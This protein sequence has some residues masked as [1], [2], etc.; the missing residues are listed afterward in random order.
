MFSCLCYSLLWLLLFSLLLLLLLLSL[1]FLLLVLLL[2][3]S[4]RHV[5]PIDNLRSSCTRSDVSACECLFVCVRV[6]ASLCVTLSW[7]VKFSSSTNGRAHS[8]AFGRTSSLC[9]HLVSLWS[10]NGIVIPSHLL[11][12]FYL[13]RTFLRPKNRLYRPKSRTESRR[14]ACVWFNFK[15]NI[16][17]V[18]EACLS[19]FDKW[20]LLMF[21]WCCYR[22]KSV[23]L[24]HTH[25]NT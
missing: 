16:H 3:S 22:A 2:P 15:N 13:L 6:T 1:S 9:I 24:V 23:V 14:A 21:K 5:T 19:V 20:K 7:N 18:T 25:F 17:N 10:L 4:V 12:G 11:C 8:I